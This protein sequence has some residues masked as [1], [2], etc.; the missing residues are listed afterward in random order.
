MDAKT[1][2]LAYLSWTNWLLGLPE[3]GLRAAHC[4][5]KYA[6]TPNQAATLMFALSLTA[7]TYFLCGRHSVAMSQVDE[8]ACLSEEK[9]A[10]QWKSYVLIQRSCVLAACDRASEA[11]TNL[12]TGINFWRSTGATADIP[13]F[14]A[15]L[16]GSQARLGQFEAAAQGMAD[17]IKTIETTKEKWCQ[18][19]VFRLAGIV[20][21]ISGTA[22]ATKAENYFNC[23]LEVARQQ[24]AK[25]WELRA[26]MSLA[27]L[28][29][30]QGKVNEA[31]ELLA[32]VYGWFTEGVR[33]ARS[34]EAK[35]LLEQMRA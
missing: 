29:R 18:A 30:D 16:A 31:R 32:P 6:R 34:E 20:A 21:L 24:Q 25:S 11:V 3:A 12:A 13:L 33:H 22:D 7:F 9:G 26:A 2:S 23:A 28:W 5:V 19:E 35:A 14:Q 10:E 1:I 4:A 27:R 8:L 15:L 17:A